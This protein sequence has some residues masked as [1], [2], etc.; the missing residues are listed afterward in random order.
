[1]IYRRVEARSWISVGGSKAKLWGF[2]KLFLR[3]TPASFEIEMNL[4]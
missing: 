1:L 2:A 4:K 3:N